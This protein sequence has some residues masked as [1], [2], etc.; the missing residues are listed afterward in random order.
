MA[1]ENMKSR[2]WKIAKGLAWGILGLFAFFVILIM[3]IYF[4]YPSSVISCDT[5]ECFVAFANN[6]SETQFSETNALGQFNYFAK[7]C[8]FSKT[9]VKTSENELPEIKEIV[10]GKSLY[11]EYTSGNFDERWISSIALG[12]DFCWGDLKEA[13]GELFLFSD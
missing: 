6:C 5:Q 11:C 8:I 10:E 4:F 7:D 9:L 1:I 12:I 13:I 2:V 3:V